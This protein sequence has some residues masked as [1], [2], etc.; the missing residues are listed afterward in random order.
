MFSCVNTKAR[1]I[2]SGAFAH[3]R[4]PLILRIQRATMPK[5]F[6]QQRMPTYPFSRPL[7]SPC[8]LQWKRMSYTHDEAETSNTETPLVDYWRHRWTLF[9]RLLP[10]H[11]L[12]VTPHA[13]RSSRHLILNYT[14]NYLSYAHTSSV[15]L[16]STPQ[17]QLHCTHLT[18]RTDAYNPKR[19]STQPTRHLLANPQPRA[20][21]HRS[22]LARA[23]LLVV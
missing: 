15:P 3:L 17:G 14:L 10:S 19:R 6:A 22:R 4:G 7:T 16:K 21:S 2:A 20:L 9:S 18:Q 13:L 12:L 5:N 23:T 8:H 1:A 11:R